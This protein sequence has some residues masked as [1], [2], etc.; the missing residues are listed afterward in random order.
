[1][2]NKDGETPIQG[3]PLTN[4]VNHCVNHQNG[5]KKRAETKKNT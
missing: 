3:F 4:F 1:M 5:E 2:Q